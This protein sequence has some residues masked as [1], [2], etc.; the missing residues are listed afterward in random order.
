[1][2]D[3][4]T[5]W[6][7]FAALAVFFIAY[8]LVIAEETLHLRKSKPVMV[9]GRESSGRWW[10]FVYAQHGDTH[11]AEIGGTPQSA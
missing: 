3:L 1:V 10:R 5:H 8:G 2:L 6:A 11:T 4:T 7:G 9:G